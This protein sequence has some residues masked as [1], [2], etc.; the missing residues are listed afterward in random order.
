MYVYTYIY[1]VLL[2]KSRVER[3]VSRL[4]YLTICASTCGESCRD[5]SKSWKHRSVIVTVTYSFLYA[6]YLGHVTLQTFGE[7]S[8]NTRWTDIMLI[9]THRH[10]Y[11]HTQYY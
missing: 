10:T 7:S 1:L 2:R 3:W 11:T 9:H 5:R 4:W 8:Q 6:I